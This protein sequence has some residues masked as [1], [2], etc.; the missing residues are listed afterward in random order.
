MGD[1]ILNYRPTADQEGL[2]EA[3]THLPFDP[4]ASSATLIDLDIECPKCERP[5]NICKSPPMFRG[6]VGWARLY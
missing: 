5:I 6:S 3:G 2:W 4:F 1:D